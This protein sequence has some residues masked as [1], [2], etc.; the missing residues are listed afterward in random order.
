[1]PMI[2]TVPSALP[3]TVVS[4]GVVV[5]WYV[6]GGARGV[7]GA[8]SPLIPTSR[9]TKPG[10]LAG[11]THRYSSSAIHAPATYPTVPK[12]QCMSCISLKKYP[13]TTTTLP[14]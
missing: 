5:Y 2:V 3:V 14:P 1:M 13:A 7:R 8:K 6:V 4:S 11:A 9:I 10:A 12:R